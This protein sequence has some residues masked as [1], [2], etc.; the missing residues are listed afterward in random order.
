M[1]IKFGMLLIAIGIMAITIYSCGPCASCGDAQTSADSTANKPPSEADVYLNTNVIFWT[2]SMA[3]LEKYLKRRIE[4]IEMPGKDTKSKFLVKYLSYNDVGFD[5]LNIYE[6]EA[7]KQK[8]YEEKVVAIVGNY[9]N[10]SQEKK[11]Y[12]IDAGINIRSEEH[13]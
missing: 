3:D 1:K 6:S 2:A 10:L 8:L 4:P 11:V 13:T 7:V 5:S 9:F 12:N